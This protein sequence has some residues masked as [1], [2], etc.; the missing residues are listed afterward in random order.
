MRTPIK[1]KRTRLVYYCKREWEGKK[2]HD[3]KTIAV[4]EYIPLRGHGKPRYLKIYDIP[5]TD[6]LKFY[7]R[8]PLQLLSDNKNLRES[9][10]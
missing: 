10:Y 3:Y 9:I 8:A 7:P 5:G 6:E 2:F 4:F 1:L